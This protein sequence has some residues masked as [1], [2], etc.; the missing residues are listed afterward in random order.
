MKLAP[1]SGLP[2]HPRLR[3]RAWLP[4]LVL[5]V[6]HLAL[7]LD[8]ASKQGGT[9]DEIIYAPSGYSYWKT[10]DFRLNPEHPPFLK[11]WLALPLLV[12][13]VDVSAVPGWAK[14]N[15]WLYGQRFV[16]D[17]GLA[18]SSILFRSRMMV[19]LLSALLAMGVWWTARHLGGDAPGL[20]ALALY[21]LDPLVVAHAGLATT[22]LGTSAFYFFAALSFPAAIS[23]GG[24]RRLVTAGVLLGL[25]L[26]SKHSTLLLLAILFSTMALVLWQNRRQHCSEPGPAIESQQPPAPGT[27]PGL[28]L[29]RLLEVVGL[30]VAV[31]VLCHGP[32]GPGLYLEGLD[33]QRVHMEQG[34]PAYAFGHYSMKGWWWYFPAAWAVKTPIPL[35]LATLAGVILLSTRLRA[36]PLTNAVPLLALALPWGAALATPLNTGVR[37][38]LP[39]VP[40]LAVAGGLALA[41]CLEA[42][43][44]GAR[45]GLGP[46]R[47]AQPGHVRRPPQR[48]EL[49]QR[50]LGRAHPAVAAPR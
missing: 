4:A 49:F 10:G 44:C 15:E 19:A 18:P 9:F 6:L 35:L 1:P 11:L 17:S 38:L 31:L 27:T 41:G 48:V 43:T 34:H 5:G 24:Q 36:S 7:V 50:A 26:A 40:F 12:E 33:I 16:Y 42:G 13:H 29:L 2:P 45:R 14:K 37:Y 39:A 25:A 47:V 30:G 28:V 8:G 46:H 20:F 32:A 22:D 3:P 21:A 23:Q